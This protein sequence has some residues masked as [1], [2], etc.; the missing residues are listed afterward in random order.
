[1]KALS[2]KTTLA[3]AVIAAFAAGCRTTPPEAQPQTIS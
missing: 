1:M 3:L 2:M